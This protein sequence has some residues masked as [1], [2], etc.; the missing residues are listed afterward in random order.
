MYNFDAMIDRVPT[1]SSKWTGHGAVQTAQKRTLCYTTADMDF[2]CPPCVLSGIR[3]RLEHPILGYTLPQRALN[4]S[5]AGWMQRRHGTVFD[6]AWV[7]QTPGIIT[8][9]AF[10]LRA[11]VPQGGRVLVFTPVYNPFF[12]ITEGAGYELVECPLLDCDRHYEIDFDRLER[13]CRKGLGTILFCNPHNP[14]GRVWTQEELHRLAS[15]CVKYQVPIVSDEAHADFALFGSRFTS[16]LSVPELAG[17]CV[18]CLS[19]SK[20][21]NIPGEGSAYLVTPDDALRARVNAALQSAWINSPPIL[22]RAAA[23]A[24]YDG[25]DSWMDELNAYLEEN[26]R[27]LFSFLREHMPLVLPALQEGTFLFWLDCSCFGL[28]AGEL[29]PL[30]VDRYNVSWQDGSVYRGDGARHLRINIACPRQLLL[31]GLQAAAQCYQAIVG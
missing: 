24:G 7:K 29:A 30:L 9:L 15:L 31:D 6:P 23:Q 3:S 2:A 17:Q 26:A 21:F 27:T 10:A 14:V 19:P 12:S 13:E 8:G 11:L 22:C 28:P 1:G 25:A 4:E 5:L 16:I 18:V 20:S